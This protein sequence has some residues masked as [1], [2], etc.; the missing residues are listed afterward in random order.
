VRRGRLGEVRDCKVIP[1]E[2]LAAQHRLLVVDFIVEKKKRKRR[3]REK[4]IIWWKL[5]KEEGEELVQRLSEKFEEI[6]ESERF[7]WG[8]TFPMVIDT[9][10]EV[11]G[12]SIPGKYLEKESWW[13]NEEVE[14]AVKEKTQA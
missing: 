14:K 5:R 2:S 13:W 10:K 4:Q 3:K 9:A 12:E 6:E 8:E 7:C 1:G 11:L